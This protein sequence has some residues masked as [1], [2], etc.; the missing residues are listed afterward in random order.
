MFSLGLEL[1]AIE[2]ERHHSE[3]T[4]SLYINLSLNGILIQVLNMSRYL[5]LNVSENYEREAFPMKLRFKKISFELFTDTSKVNS[6]FIC[7]FY[8]CGS[9]IT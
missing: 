1:Q 8:D 7:I 5:I 4:F 9:E 6:N 2:S 3:I